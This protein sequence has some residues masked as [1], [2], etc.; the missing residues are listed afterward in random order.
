MFAQVA[1]PLSFSEPFTYRIPAHLDGKIAPGFRVL[2]QLRKK[3]VTGFVVDLS[4]TSPVSN[5]KD[6]IDL[7]DPYPLFSREMLE[8][9]KWVSEYYLCSWGETLRAA[10]PSELMLKSQMWV[11]RGGQGSGLRIKVQKWGADL[12][13]I[14]GAPVS[15]EGLSSRQEGILELLD[16]GQ[17]RK[18]SW[19]SRTLGTK[20][21]YADIY[22][23]SQRGEIQIAE[24]LDKPGVSVRYEKMVRLRNFDRSSKDSG[25]W[26]LAVDALEKKS[27]A[28]AKCLQL[29]VANRGE[30]SW[31]AL[32]HQHQAG[33]SA[34]KGLERRGLIELG[35]VEKVR[36]SDWG[37]D[38]PQ[39][40]QSR[41][42]QGQQEIFTRVRE[43]LRKAVYSPFLIHGVTGSGKTQVYIEAIK[44]VLEDGKQ[45]LILV[46]EIALTPQI[47]SRFKA[48][49]YEKVGCFHSRLSAGE[50]F[51]TWRRVRNGDLPVVVG[52]RSGVF[53]PFPNL[54]L[55]VVDEEH[56][57]SYKQD[58]PAPRYNARDVAV[59]R[60]KLNRAVVILGS[61]TP[62]L[63]SYYNA[64]K[65]KYA[66]CELAERVERQKLP[67][68]KIVN[69]IQERKD[70]NRNAI[71]RSLS[72]LL[73]DRVE[74]GEQALLF[75]NRRGFS[76]FVKCQDCG[77]IEKCPRCNITLTFHRTDFSLRCHYC[78][79]RRRA[80]ELCP[81]CHGFSFMY[82]G[83]GTQKIEEEIKRDFP[84]AGMERMDLDTTLKK[85]AHRRILSDFGRK[86]FNIL[87][88][89]QM[90]TKGL[91]F[92]DV[93]LVGV[94]SA[95]LGLD[96]PDFRSRERTF[97]LLAQVAGRAG[98]GKREGEVVIQT[99]YPEEWAIQL[100]SSHDFVSFFQRELEQRR[101]LG[102]PPF[103]HLI[104]ILISGSDLG[105]VTAS[106][107]S[108][109]RRLKQK[110]KLKGTKEVEILGPAPAPLSKIKNQHRWQL[111][112]KTKNAT[113]TGSLIRDLLVA[114]ENLRNRKGVR[115]TINVDPMGML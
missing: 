18:L 64:Q 43:A 49:F 1:L 28:Q 41:L 69:L 85:G 81:N 105:H 76:T 47:I 39:L 33:P 110:V 51:D 55:I 73:K 45:A 62:S 102:Y 24:R 112:V 61:A 48:N 14:V 106:A 115:I 21:L 71:S 82:K 63:E 46:P 96:L 107:Q 89:T 94:I 23:L 11:R 29:L 77:Y 7:L 97:Q 95:D 80:P 72:S 4:K 42:N 56:D 75:L 13:S 99:Y 65:G 30:L 36:E 91:D 50:R 10:I 109:S 67:D 84:L 38:L 88:G 17:E 32:V 16:D 98:R 108:F 114:D 68:V 86:K 26:E 103:K 111:L 79:Y 59:M 74:K 12:G 78:D 19:L 87:L 3:T 58:D 40:P 15:T 31:T 52:A 22:D 6:I 35:K 8:L 44:E 83:M 100:A 54:A 5:I 93:T 25:L 70:G 2:V 92:P 27:L 66:L 34:L 37:L 104:L 57:P 113:S 101:E 53:L 60:G 20:G 9:T 90:I